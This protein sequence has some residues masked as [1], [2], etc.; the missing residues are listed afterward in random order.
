[1]K[2]KILAIIPVRGGSKG[3]PKKNIKPLFGKPLITWT[4]EQVQ[5]SRYIFRVFV[6]TD[7]K[8]IATIAEK[9]GVDIPF[10]R[11]YEFAQEYSPTS[12]AII[13]T[14]D[15]FEKMGEYYDILI[16][17]E[18]TFPLREK[19]DIDKVIETYLRNSSDSESLV[20]V[21]EVQL[22]NPYIMK[23]IDNNHVIPFLENKKKFYQR[24]QLLPIYFPYGLIYLSTVQAFRESGTF[25]Q[26][27]TIPYKIERRQNYEIDDIYEFYCVETILKNKLKEVIG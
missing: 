12:D 3:I 25:Y 4:I 19:D 18:P 14:L 2:P 10:L 1:M 23:I 11:Q 21:G 24:Q 15:T 5:K 26:K 9:G 20:S 13:H 8:E 16:I 22:E 17:L 7:D 6:S 27:I